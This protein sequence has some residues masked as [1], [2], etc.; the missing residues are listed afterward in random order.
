M[1]SLDVMCIAS[2]PLSKEKKGGSDSGCGCRCVKKISIDVSL[3]SS[4]LTTSRNTIA[5]TNINNIIDNNMT[6]DDAVDAEYK[7]DK[8][9]PEI[10][11]EDETET[12][13]QDAGSDGEGDGDGDGEK[14]GYYYRNRE[15]KLEYQKKYNREQGDKIKNY[16]KDYYQKKREEILEKAKTKIMCECGCEV[17]L[18]NMNSHKKTK[19][20]AKALQRV[21]REKNL[22][23]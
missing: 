17:Q 21:M 16:N 11:M 1:A 20:H 22:K 10:V 6:C 5:G 19:K 8:D 15:R 12:R 3:I 2:S 9:R 18:F 14:N 13:R 7:N 23:L 4:L